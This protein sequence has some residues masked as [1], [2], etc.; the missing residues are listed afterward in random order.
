[1]FHSNPITH[2]F[3]ALQLT[4]RILIIFIVVLSAPTA[5]SWDARWATAGLG[6]ET[7]TD[8]CMDDLG[9]VY[10]AGWATISGRGDD[11]M[12]IIKYSADGTEQWSHTWDLGYPGAL[13]YDQPAGIGVD[14]A[15]NVY[16]SGR[17]R[18]ERS[19]TQ[20]YD[21]A[22]IKYNADGVFQ[23]D[24][25]YDWLG[26]SS[27][28]GDDKPAGMAVD[29][30]GNVY[31]TGDS[32]AEYFTIKY[33]SAG[34]VQWTERFAADFVG[35]VSHCTAIAIDDAGN[36]YITG[37]S[38]DENAN[39]DYVTISYGPSGGQR[40]KSRY[41]QVAAHEF[42]PRDIAVSS[43]GTV[44]VTGEANFG[45]D[46]G[47]FDIAT[48]LYQANNGTQ[49]WARS[50]SGT[51]EDG[52]FYDYGRAVAFGPDGSVHVAGEGQ[53]TGNGN[54]F[55]AIKYSA[56][57]TEEWVRTHN[58]VSSSDSDSYDVAY[59]IGVDLLGN[60]Y[61]AGGL[62]RPNNVWW[63]FDYA[64]LQYTPDGTLQNSSFYDSSAD[65]PQDDSALALALNPDGTFA[66]TGES[67]DAYTNYDI[68]TSQAGST[69]GL[70]FAD[71][72]E[73]GNLSGW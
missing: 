19:G 1:M 66:V 38:M 12:V 25:L 7:G 62:Q 41:G 27:P 8:I 17:A 67:W 30:A 68:A 36:S 57:G 48:V 71:G 65:L 44:A 63:E 55:V 29:S 21:Y 18:H 26:G 43:T 40:W 32:D 39:W 20:D 34:V 45:T 2:Q 42:R 73:S 61:V 15:G 10:V 14:S 52:T 56:G 50:W 51:G 4:A 28:H 64:V 33:N 22:T 16:V 13:Y 69:T 24:E 9:N 37:Y 6:V 5:F 46:V 35:A 70:I 58:E 72:F 59:D 3:G 49:V 23:W 60:V 11:D 53:M 47:V 54:D 31:V